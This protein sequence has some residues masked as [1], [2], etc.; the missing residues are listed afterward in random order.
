MFSKSAN[1]T[2]LR[3]ELN[4]ENRCGLL[5]SVDPVLIKQSREGLNISFTC[6]EK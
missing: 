4:D 2:K 6:I 3:P 5:W 1:Y